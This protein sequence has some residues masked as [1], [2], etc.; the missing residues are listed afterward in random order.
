MILFSTSVSPLKQW[1]S[2]SKFSMTVGRPDLHKH[3]NG[4]SG[5]MLFLPSGLMRRRLEIPI[6]ILA[7]PGLVWSGVVW[8]GLAWPGLAVQREETCHLITTATMDARHLAPRRKSP[9][10][11]APPPPWKTPFSNCYAGTQT[12]MQHVRCDDGGSAAGKT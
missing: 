2:F 3:V 11:P 6:S 4:F 8:S 1:P 7:R 5:H 10:D 12:P 9:L